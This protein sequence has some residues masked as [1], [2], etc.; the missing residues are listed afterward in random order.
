M[1]LKLRSQR[2]QFDIKIFVILI[3]L[4]VNSYRKIIGPLGH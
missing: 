1:I 4:E 2:T 3:I